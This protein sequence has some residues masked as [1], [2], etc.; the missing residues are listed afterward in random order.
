MAHTARFPQFARLPQEIQMMI[1]KEI[2]ETPRIVQICGDSSKYTTTGEICH[3]QI[4]PLLQACRQSRL[5][6]QQV[7]VD[8]HFDDRSCA[9]IYLQPRLDTLYYGSANMSEDFGSTGEIW[10]YPECKTLDPSDVATVAFEANWWLKLDKEGAQVYD[11]R[12]FIGLTRLIIVLEEKAEPD[13]V[14]QFVD[15]T[16]EEHQDISGFL[17]D[18]RLKTSAELR[19]HVREAWKV[20]FEEWDLPASEMPEI[21][22]KK[23]QGN[24]LGQTLYGEATLEDIDTSSC[25]TTETE[26]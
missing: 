2:L 12:F 22:I 21:V 14:A 9:F 17:L 15:L 3:R 5:L 18:S 8:R 25:S 13:R 11:M 26:P 23:L 10:S 1:W 16:N 7:F 20:E 6:A 24:I 4:P 19:D